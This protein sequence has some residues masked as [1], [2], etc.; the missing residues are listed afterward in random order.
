[1]GL[2][3]HGPRAAR[4]A[5]PR[6]V[7]ACSGY[8]VQTGDLN[9]V[10]DLGPGSLANLQRHIGLHGSRR[11]GAQPQPSGPLGRP[12]GAAH[13]VAATASSVEGVPVFGT[14]ETHTA[15]RRRLTSSLE[16][17]FD[18]H[19]TGDGDEFAIGRLRFR[20]RPPTTTSRRSAVRVDDRVG[21]TARR[22]LGRHRAGLVARAARVGT[23]PGAV[24][25]DLSDRRGSRRRSAPERPHR[26]VPW[27]RPQV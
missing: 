11:G 17:T 24:R 18:W 22:L 7:E 16:P 27:A 15:C 13:R 10:V 6:S 4:A 21:R 19:E 12:H 8:L 26:P 5:T 14:A 2:T 23:R 9:V 1:M 20:S 25:V 3:R